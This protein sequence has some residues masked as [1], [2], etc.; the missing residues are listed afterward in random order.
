MPVPL[1]SIQCI[2][3]KLDQFVY[4]LH[5]RLLNMAWSSAC[6]TV[7]AVGTA[8]Y[9]RQHLGATYVCWPDWCFFLGFFSG[10]FWLIAAAVALA[11]DTC[12]S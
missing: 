4:Q 5:R 11:G 2:E 9:T 3:C 10:V 8:I 12:P 7:I 6:Y 1:G